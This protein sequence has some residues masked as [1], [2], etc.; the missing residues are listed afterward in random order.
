MNIAA[1]VLDPGHT[2][3]FEQARPL[4]LDPQQLDLRR[5]FELASGETT[6]QFDKLYHQEAAT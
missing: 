5:D 2:G 3:P 1:T 4:S 6:R